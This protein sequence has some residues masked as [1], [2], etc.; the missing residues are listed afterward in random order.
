MRKPE[1]LRTGWKGAKTLNS[2]TL[3]AVLR[4]LI[5]VSQLFALSWLATVWA[6]QLIG[7]EVAFVAQMGVVFGHFVLAGEPQTTNLESADT[8]FDIGELGSRFLGRVSDVAGATMNKRG[9][10]PGNQLCA[11]DRSFLVFGNAIYLIVAKF[12]KL[13]KHFHGLFSTEATIAS[14]LAGQNRT[15]E[16]K[17]LLNFHYSPLSS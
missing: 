11:S 8:V 5:A 10:E 16:I 6:Y 4:F 1:G 9:F 12:E 17:N 14:L 13:R 2:G 3:C 15:S 7:R